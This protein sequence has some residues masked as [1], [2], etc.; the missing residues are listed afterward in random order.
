MPAYVVFQLDKIL[1]INKE[2]SYFEWEELQ[3]DL[4]R[5]APTVDI[6]FLKTISLYFSKLLNEILTVT[7]VNLASYR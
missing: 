3:A 5:L 1:D 7:D 2:T 4:G 6:G